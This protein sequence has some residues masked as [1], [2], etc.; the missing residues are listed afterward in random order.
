[1]SKLEHFGKNAIDYWKHWDR[2][3]LSVEGSID[4][5]GARAE[6]IRYGT[7]WDIVEQNI[8]KVVDANIKTAPNTSIGCYN[9][10]RL[11][12]LLEELWEL[13]QQ[14]NQINLNP[15]FN[16]W[17]RI[18]T[19]PDDWKQE[20]KTKLEKIRDKGTIKITRLEKILIELDRPH[21]PEQVRFL[22]KRLSF[23]DMNKKKTV[24]EAIP[25]ISQLND[26]YGGMYEKFRNEWI[27]KSTN[28]RFDSAYTYIPSSVHN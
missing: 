2:Q 20:V 18:N 15:V 5:T 28:P 23:L 27:E 12:E 4:E 25:E 17:C 22:F 8:K 7:V 16:V 6:Y 19:I 11:P 3:K 9:I 21:N 1:M 10:M 13:Y 24:L 14:P 26:R